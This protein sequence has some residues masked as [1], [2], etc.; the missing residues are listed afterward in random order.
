[1]I[2]TNKS[3]IQGNW[4][5]NIIQCVLTRLTRWDF[6]RGSAPFW[7]LYANFSSHQWLIYQENE[8]ELTESNLALIPPDTEY[9]GRLKG[10]E[11]NHFFIHFT[12]S[13][14][15]DNAG[16][17]PC[18]LG[19]DRFS[20]GLLAPAEAF[21]RSGSRGEKPD[22]SLNALALVAHNLNRLDTPPRALPPRDARI[23]WA[24]T[25]M[26]RNLPYPLDMNDLA[27]RANLSPGG[28]TRLFKEETG[29]TPLYHLNEKRIS[30][31]CE[32]LHDRDLSLEEI[33][34]QCGFANRYYFTRVFKKYRS[35]TPGAFRAMLR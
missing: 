35:N 4:N 19:R 26:A 14:P 18:F 11:S 8:T 25:Y 29:Q 27:K 20:Q 12:L 10:K 5:L 28:F 30:R 24:L 6:S 17:A 21:V 9:Q 34:E 22:L 3:L 23:E 31:A 15:I 2:Q 7:R 32:L 1:M 33:A 16:G 13:H